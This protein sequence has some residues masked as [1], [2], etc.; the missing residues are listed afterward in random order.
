MPAVDKHDEVMFNFWVS[1]QVLALYA[2]EALGEL[3][4]GV[5][6]DKY[7]KTLKKM[8]MVVLLFAC[9]RYRLFHFC[10]LCLSSTCFGRVC[11]CGV[12]LATLARVL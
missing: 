1:I 9:A 2:G 12:M 10:F 7:P 5:M 6:T 8:L 3:L 4:T 11:V